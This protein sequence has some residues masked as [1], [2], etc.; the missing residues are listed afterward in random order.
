M[1]FFDPATAS[2][3]PLSPAPFHDDFRHEHLDNKTASS[4]LIDG[5]NDEDM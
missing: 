1:I 3:I 4:L 2:R 5:T